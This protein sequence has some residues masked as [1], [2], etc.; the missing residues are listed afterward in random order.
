MMKNKIVLITGSTDGI[1]K[2][3][4]IELALLGAHVIVHGRNKT[5]VEKTVE[6]LKIENDALRIDGFTFDLS[7]LHQVKQFSDTIKNQF[8]HVDVLINNAGVYLKNKTLS[9]DG[10]EMTFAV[11][12]L[13]H[14]LLT[15]ELLPLLK[16]SNEGRIIHVSSMAHQNAKLDWNNLNSE[17][18]YDGYG[19]Y[20]LS[21]LANIIFSKEL[22]ERLN[23]SNVTSN[24]LHPGV[25][26]TKLLA[27]GFNISG[28][29]V[30]RGAENSVFLASA[31]EV[32]NTTGKYFVDKKISRY[33]SIVDDES[34]RKK[35][36]E[37]SSE[38]TGIN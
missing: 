20:S 25:I 35:I 8:D 31:R 30:K 2:Q 3:T 24:S 27:A 11:N 10:F 16:R 4:A 6:E 37:I 32:K 13:S 21:K 33:N 7:S 9:D 29:S 34:V 22:S 38:M 12:H 19:V 1:G 28:S 36:W 26:T 15:N 14:F 17:K 18:Y 5:R 23:G